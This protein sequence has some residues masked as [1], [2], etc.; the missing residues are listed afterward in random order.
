MEIN[1]PA[2]S[3]IATDHRMGVYLEANTTKNFKATFENGIGLW[4]VTD[5]RECLEC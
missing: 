1:L 2:G 5:W 3:I 4:N